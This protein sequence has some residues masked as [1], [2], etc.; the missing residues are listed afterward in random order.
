MGP[1]VRSLGTRLSL[2]SQE[3]RG[4]LSSGEGIEEPWL[5]AKSDKSHG[6]AQ[7]CHGTVRCGG[8]ILEHDV[9]N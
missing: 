6:T 9:H 7:R 4:G 2:R 1:M 8:D 5:A 3:R